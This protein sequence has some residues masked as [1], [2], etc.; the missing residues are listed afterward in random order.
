MFTRPAFGAPQTS[1]FGGFQSQSTAAPFGQQQLF[2]NTNSTFGTTNAFGSSA[3]IFGQ[4]QSSA[5]LFGSTTTTPA[6]GQPQSGFGTSLF[7]QQQ[8]QQQPSIGLFGSSSTFGQQNKPAGFGFGSTS[9]TGLFGQP[10]QQQSSSL[11]QTPA[12]TNVFG[13]SGFGSNMQPGV[14]GTV[15]KFV[16]VT[17]TDSMQRSGIAQAISTKHHCITIMKEYEGKSF[18]EL[19]WEDYQ[20]GRKGP[21]QQPAF[22]QPFGATA[23]S[24]PSLFGQN[25]QNKSVFGQSSGFGQ[26]STFGQTNSQNIFGKPSG[27]TFGTAVT[28][29][30]SFGFGNTPSTNL[31]GSNTA[32]KP[33]GTQPAQNLFGQP[34]Q[35]A[36]PAFGSSNIFGQPNTQSPSIFGKPAQPAF[37][38][39][40]TGFQFGQTNAT[41]SSSLFQAP[42]PTTGFGFS[43][44]QTNTSTAPF[45]QTQPQQQPFGGFGSTFGKPFGQTQQPTTGFGTGLGMQSGSLFGTATSKPGGLFGNTGTGAGLFTSSF[46]TATPFGLPQQPQPQQQQIAALPDPH[47]EEF[48]KIVQHYDLYGNNPA[49]EGLEPMKPAE[50]HYVT[51]PKDIQAILELTPNDPKVQSHTHKLSVYPVKK[52]VTELFNDSQDDSLEKSLYMRT[53]TRRLVLRKKP[54][55]VESKLDDLVATCMLGQTQNPNANL[56]L[57]LEPSLNKDQDPDEVSF[58]NLVSPAKVK[59]NP[60]IK[61]VLFAK[62]DDEHNEI[63]EPVFEDAIDDPE[64]FDS[65]KED[66]PSKKKKR[67]SKKIGK[68][69]Y[70]GLSEKGSAFGLLRGDDSEISFSPRRVNSPIGYES[71]MRSNKEVSPE[72]SCGVILT[73]HGY[74]TI[75]ELD[76]LH[77]YKNED[78]R[79]IISGLT[80][81][82]AGFGNVYFPNEVDITDMNLDEIVYFQHRILS[83]YPDESTKPPLGQG[84]NQEAQITLDHVY[85]KNTEG[86]EIINPQGPELDRF[87]NRLNIVSKKIGGEFKDYR[88][89]TGSWVFTVQHFSKY[90][91]LDDSDVT[92]DPAKQVDP[93]NKVLE[94]KEKTKQDEAAA[95]SVSGI[96]VQQSTLIPGQMI[97]PGFLFSDADMSSFNLP[98]GNPTMM[99]T[100]DVRALN[101]S[102]R[103]RPTGP[104]MLELGTA[105][106]SGFVIESDYELEKTGLS[107]FN[108]RGSDE[109]Q[110]EIIE[111]EPI[112]I[113]NLADHRLPHRRSDMYKPNT[114]SVFL[115][116]NTLFRDYDKDVAQTMIQSDSMSEQEEDVPHKPSIYIDDPGLEIH[117]PLQFHKLLNPIPGYVPLEK[118]YFLGRNYMDLA[119]FKSRSFK[120]GWTGNST[121]YGTAKLDPKNINY[122]L[123]TLAK[124][125]L[126]EPN[127]I[128]DKEMLDR[129]MR[130]IWENSLIEVVGATPRASV[131]ITKKALEEHCK[132]AQ[133]Y[134]NTPKGKYYKSIWGLMEAFWDKESKPLN[135]KERFST[136]L[137][138]IVSEDV[139]QDLILTVKTIE[140]VTNNILALLSGH[141]VEKA[142]LIAI[143]NNMPQLGMLLA[144]INST[145]TGK[146]LLKKQISQWVS[147]LAADKIDENTFKIYLILAGITN[148]EKANICESLDWKRA[149]AT[150]LWYIA[151]SSKPI[152]YVIQLYEQAFKTF[153]YADRP[154]PPH[155][156]EDVC[157]ILYH[158]MLLNINKNKS[159][160]QVLNTDTHTNDPTDYSLSWLLL[161]TFQSLQIGSISEGCVNHI[162]LNFASQLEA[163]G[164]YNWAIFVLSFIKDRKVRKSLIMEVLYRHIDIGNDN[165]EMESELV[166]QLRVSPVW[167]HHIKANMCLSSKRYWEAYTHL[168]FTQ[169]WIECHDIAVQQLIPILMANDQ[170]AEMKNILYPIASGSDRIPHWKNQGGL[171]LEFLQLQ[172]LVSGTTEQGYKE[173]Y[174]DVNEEIMS[175]IRRFSDFPTTSAELSLCVSEMSRKSVH[176]LSKFLKGVSPAYAYLTETE[177]YHIGDLV[178]PPD[179]K[180]ELILSVLTKYFQD[181]EC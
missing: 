100:R 30:S 175:I 4:A 155:N 17:G 125:Q 68:P 129:H 173:R 117:K 115:M 130:I 65:S 79:C 5:P 77:K 16:P 122:Q 154:N 1:G 88:P 151:P 119:L 142:A 62:D 19:R 174:L 38:Q 118:S 52:K 146:V 24:A 150:H 59:G 137:E 181:K 138:N 168:S 29:A 114:D 156:K 2:G 76:N 64:Y 73:R 91:I 123:G 149:L 178:M 95:L 140:D 139:E 45:G 84:L 3:P 92:D 50:G 170:F 101:I 80:I 94:N 89:D 164:L 34:A 70:S 44:G 97:P 49:L 166:N 41:Q 104:Q 66:D 57:T 106:F 180:V 8:Q 14:T 7:G 167:I 158:L 128:L 61:Q 56:C 136:W 153:G 9:S 109:T 143:N 58:L 144:Q 31:F 55:P 20:A 172:E 157:D 60:P 162:H 72:E 177:K 163:L 132:L 120:P 176:L 37:G 165:S 171:I 112:D 69:E 90:G 152:S 107:Q 33:F 124:F 159:L 40:T 42:K 23:S 102:H 71:I 26:T 133:S 25:D 36:Q 145:S 111:S 18:E 103:Q 81:G 141:Q 83:V 161:M 11:F 53:S 105:P 78:G 51:N 96:P 85:P 126:Y 67:K 116:K 74:Y 43:F 21:Q 27:S 15:V 110:S 108:Q 82:K 48:Q 47:P 134:E 75:P 179:Y 46:Q 160:E 6:F 148:T 87:L 12:S 147:S 39:P 131:K 99:L 86:E 121:F 169:R 22:G 54:D 135:R 127:E 93:K 13:S 63:S 35:P 10:A 32:A 28:T 98:Y 113:E